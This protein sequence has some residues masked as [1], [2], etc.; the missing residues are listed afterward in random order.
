MIP[1]ICVDVKGRKE[2]SVSVA[3]FWAVV[4]VEEG[5]ADSISRQTAKQRNIWWFIA[6]G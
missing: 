5:A 6:L 4:A 3:C 2:K 1:L